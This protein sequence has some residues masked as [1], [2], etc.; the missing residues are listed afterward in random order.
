[1]LPLSNLI[2]SDSRDVTL[3]LVKYMI[4]STYRTIVEYRTIGHADWWTFGILDRFISGG[5][6]GPFHGRKWD[7]FRNCKHPLLSDS[8]LSVCLNRSFSMNQRILQHK[9]TYLLTLSVRLLRGLGIYCFSIELSTIIL[10]Q[11][12]LLVL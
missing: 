12:F 6:Y 1:M 5:I 4:Q 8:F 7:V 3:M 10:C 11:R 2:M 9:F